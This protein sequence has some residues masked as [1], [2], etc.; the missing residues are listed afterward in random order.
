MRNAPIRVPVQYHLS[1]TP[2][3]PKCY[4]STTYVKLQYQLDGTESGTENGYFITSEYGFSISIYENMIGSSDNKTTHLS[5]EP[6]KEVHFTYGVHL[7]K[8]H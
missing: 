7:N 8:T 2:V 5:D 3:L 1:V 6:K 4:S